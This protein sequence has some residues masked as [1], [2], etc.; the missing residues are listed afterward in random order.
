MRRVACVM[1]RP[2]GSGTFDEIDVGRAIAAVRSRDRLG[3]RWPL[4][5]AVATEIPVGEAGLK[6]RH[7]RLGM[8]W[9]RYREFCHRHAYPEA[10]PAAR[11]SV[12]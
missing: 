7:L 2:K 3:D 6:S 11:K 8:S 5:S 12:A 1:A 10:R 9:E 4:R